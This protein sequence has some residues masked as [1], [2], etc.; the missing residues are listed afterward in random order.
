METKHTP[1]PIE[2]GWTRTSGIVQYFIQSTQGAETTEEADANASLMER[3]FNN[4]EELVMALKNVADALSSAQGE[5]A[6]VT[7]LYAPES[8]HALKDAEE[9]ARAALAKAEGK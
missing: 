5:W 1:G 7:K 2:I 3:G 4:Y 6:S 9:E 8:T